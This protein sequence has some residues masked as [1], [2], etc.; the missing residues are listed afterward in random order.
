MAPGDGAAGAGRSMGEDTLR[1][2][3]AV[4]MP[5]TVPAGLQIRAAV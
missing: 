2:S 4:S 1:G 3:I 5:E